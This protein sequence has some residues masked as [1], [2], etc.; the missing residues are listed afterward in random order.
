M[1]M[2]NLP[3]SVLP[4]LM[5]I[6]DLLWELKHKAVLCIVL[7]ST[8]FSCSCGFTTIG[9][10]TIFTSPFGSHGGTRGLETVGW[11]N[12]GVFD[13]ILRSGTSGIPPAAD[14]PGV[15]TDPSG[16]DVSISDS[17]WPYMWLRHHNQNGMFQISDPQILGIL[18]LNSL[19]GRTYKIVNLL[20]KS[21]MYLQ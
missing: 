1:M 13:R 17:F 16:I 7:G 5:N 4:R 6:L 19:W 21:V 20:C 2:P 8:N 12:A 15:G 11:D 10:S 9:W 14:S 3:N 18:M